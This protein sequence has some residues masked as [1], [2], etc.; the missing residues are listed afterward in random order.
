MHLN[1]Q[2]GF[3]IGITK[4][5]HLFRFSG[6]GGGGSFL[7]SPQSTP[8]LRAKSRVRFERQPCLSLQKETLF[9]ERFLTMRGDGCFHLC[10]DN[11]GGGKA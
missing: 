10:P 1:E 11:S 8:R 2:A 5:D 6:T 7:Q 9:P 3:P 4:A